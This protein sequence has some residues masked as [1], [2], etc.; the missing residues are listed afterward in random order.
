RPVLANA[1]IPGRGYRHDT[2]LQS[3]VLEAH[4]TH[5]LEALAERHLGRRGL[6]Y[7]ELCG[8]WASST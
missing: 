8:L 2:L 1:G 5:S 4:R 3:Y 7:E 6:S